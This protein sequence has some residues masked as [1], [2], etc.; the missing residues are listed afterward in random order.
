[1]LLLGITRRPPKIECAE[2]DLWYWEVD[3]QGEKLADGRR[4]RKATIR[5]PC[6]AD[7]LRSRTGGYIRV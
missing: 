2:Q 6:F 4:A 5:R 7:T 3:E 1:M